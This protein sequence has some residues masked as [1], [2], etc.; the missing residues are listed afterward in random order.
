MALLQLVGNLSNARRLIFYIYKQL[1]IVD[2]VHNNYL[3]QKL[4]KCTSLNSPAML[5]A[6]LAIFQRQIAYPHAKYKE[7]IS[8]VFWC[9][10]QVTQHI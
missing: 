8:S 5:E 7:S 3:L 10:V 1:Y 2:I 9:V 4:H 6:S